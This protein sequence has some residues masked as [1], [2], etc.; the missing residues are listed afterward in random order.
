[1]HYCFDSPPVIFEQ[2]INM[3]NKRMEQKSFLATISFLL[4]YVL[5]L[6]FFRQL[7]LNLEKDKGTILKPEVFHIFVICFLI[8]LYYFAFLGLAFFSTLGSAQKVYS[9]G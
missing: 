7:L 8:L 4:F 5:F 9:I 2:T 3:L 1:M 6:F